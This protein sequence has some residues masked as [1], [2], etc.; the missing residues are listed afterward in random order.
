MEPEETN[1]RMVAPQGEAG[2]APTSPVTCSVLTC[3]F[4]GTGGGEA[5]VKEGRVDEWK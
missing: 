4:H 3:L 1:Q 2:Q 5:Q